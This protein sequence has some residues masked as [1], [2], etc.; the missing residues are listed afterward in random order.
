MPTR[1]E[2]VPLAEQ[3]KRARDIA[4]ALT[5]WVAGFPFPDLEQDYEFVALRHPDEY[6]FNEGRLV[7]SKGMDIAISDYADHFEER[8]VAHSTALHSAIRA[9]G[10]YLVGPLAR[11][12]LNFDRLPADIQALAKE[13][14]LGPVCRNPF[15][16]IL[17]RS[18]ELVFACD[19][20]L[21]VIAAYD[22]PDPF[23]PLE[24][25]ARHR[26]RLHRGA[27]RHLLA[28]LRLRRRRQC[29]RGAD[30][31]ADLAEPAVDRGRSQGGG[32]GHA[33]PAGR[34]DPPPLRT[35]D[36]QLRSLHLVFD[37]FPEAERDPAMTTLV[38]GL[39]NPDR[40]DDGVGALALAALAGRLPADVRSLARR[41]DM[42]ALLDDWQGVDR[43]ICIDAAQ[44]AGQPGRISRI[45][46]GSA[47]LPADGAPASGHAF[48]LAEALALAQ[49]L[50]RAPG[51]VV[52][53]AVEA[54]GFGVGAAVTPA[55][56]AAA[57]EVAGRVLAELGAG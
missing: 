1:A 57:A 50:G 15:Q 8:H 14:G 17:V 29:H 20:A 27:A 5:R 47:P 46:P 42:L 34:G 52:V 40:G 37:A 7:S 39:G 25:R 45:D 13:T 10:A 3:L 51:E 31:A 48:G 26:L 24:P 38:M 22:P 18:L 4:V 23:V 41:G 32:L 28:H 6:P 2:L 35:G 33:G 55:V 56:A 11:Y 12:A 9:R 54:Q 21:R 16:S 49:V 44:P 36:P 30:R 19:E 53:W 43:L